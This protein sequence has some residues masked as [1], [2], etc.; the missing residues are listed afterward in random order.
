MVE[1]KERGDRIEAGR[2]VRERCDQLQ[3]RRESD[4]DPESICH[5]R[6]FLAREGIDDPDNEGA[7][8]RS[9]S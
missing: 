9:G 5:V 4:S 7:A 8:A 6:D 1:L 2:I 3:R